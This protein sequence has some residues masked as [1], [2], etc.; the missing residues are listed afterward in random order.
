MNVFDQAAR[1][2]LRP[3]PMGF[4]RWLV[5]GLDPALRFAEWLD[6]RTLP[7]PGEPDRTCDTVAALVRDGEPTV[8]ALVTEFQAEPDPEML[9]RLL[10]YLAWLRR[11]F[12]HGPQPRDK[13]EVIAALVNLTGP[14]QPDTLAMVLP[15]IESPGLSLKVVVRTLREEDASAILTAIAEGRTAACLLPWISLMKGADR[16]DMIDVWKQRA[17]EV[18]DGLLRTQYGAL[19]VVFAELANRHGQWK[20]ALE[21]WNVR[22][23]TVVAEWTAEAKAEGRAEGRAEGEILGKVKYAHQALLCALQNLF[24]SP[25]PHDVVAAVEAQTDL[26]QLARWFEE[27]FRVSSLEEFLS[28]IRG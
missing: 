15:G 18:P 24:T 28:R 21:G 19:A 4:L 20:Q 11:G 22:E 3:D 13:Y 2:A 6:T 23:S 27:A 26:D 7:L 5:P 16:P 12:R 1:F 9:D 17:G 8:W 14:P 10:E 25:L